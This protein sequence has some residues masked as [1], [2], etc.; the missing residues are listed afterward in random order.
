M[1]GLNCP[2]CTNA[3]CAA[4]DSGTRL[5]LCG[6][7]HIKKYA[8]GQ[9]LSMRYWGDCLSVLLDGLTISGEVD[10]SGSKFVTSGLAC[11]GTI[12]SAKRFLD[13]QAATNDAFEVLCL[14]SCTVAVFDASL[15]HELLETNVSFMKIFYHQKL[16]FCGKETNEFL[17]ETGSKDAYAAVRF[18]VKYCAQHN[19]PPLTHLQPPQADG[20]RSHAQADSKRTGTFHTVPRSGMKPKCSAP[21]C[22]KRGGLFYRWVKAIP[23]ATSGNPVTL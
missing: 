18:V 6:G 22:E 1:I 9:R 2:Y 17:R 16:N 15:I 23:S 14:S 13:P 21:P 20:H 10:S 5:R 8:G 4:F 12:I 3:F 19:L 11:G 7:C